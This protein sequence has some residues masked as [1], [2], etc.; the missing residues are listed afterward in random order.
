MVW[1]QVPYSQGPWSGPVIPSPPP[2][3]ALPPPIPGGTTSY[4]FGVQQGAYPWSYGGWGGAIAPFASLVGGIQAVPNPATGTVTVYCWWPYATALQLTRTSTDGVRTPVR[5]AS[6]VTPSTSTLVNYAT[7]PAGISTSGYVPGTGSP[8]MSQITRTDSIG[9]FAIRA[10]NASS[11]TSE[12]TV[13]QAIPGGLPVTVGVDLQ[14][15]ARPTSCTITLGWND[16][17]GGAL[18]AT[19]VALTANQINNSVGQFSRQ[20]IQVT[21][22]AAA[23]TCSTLKV[24][25]GGMPAAGTVDFDRWMMVQASTDGTYGDGDMLGGIWNGTS[26]LSTSTISPVQIAID[27]ECPLDVAVSYTM[28]A[29]LL[30]GGYA[31]SQ[32]ITLA[33]QGNSWLTH[34]STP[35]VPVPCSPTVTPTLTRKIQQG[36]FQAIGAKF[37]TT[38]SASART[39][40]AGSFTFDCQSFSDR[41]ILLGLLQ[42][43]SAMLLRA[44]ADFGYGQGMWL[45]FADVVEDPKG[46]PAWNG[47]RPLTCQFQQVDTPAGPNTL[48]A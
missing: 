5:G 11:G 9:G 43:G 29:T 24:N 31:T 17:L 38:I 40:P 45:S 16:A 27:G 20:V 48:V 33:S 26:G 30:T 6:P 46:R 44:P 34:P 14:F 3:Q 32:T 37:P 22:P 1:S 18:T 28:Y 7:N 25:A 47:S 15:S 2:N 12:V 19:A 21:P 42:D 39:A 10:T 35:T 4:T 36:T 23:A 41:D 13:P 8:T